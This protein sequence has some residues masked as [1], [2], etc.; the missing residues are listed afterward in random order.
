MHEIWI[1]PLFGAVNYQMLCGQKEIANDACSNLLKQ[2]Y[3][4]LL[5]YIYFEVKVV[6]IRDATEL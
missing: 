5:T 6:M 4:K 2:T 3:K 1:V